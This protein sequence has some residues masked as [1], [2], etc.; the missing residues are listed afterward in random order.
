MNKLDSAVQQIVSGVPRCKTKTD[1]RELI[2]KVLTEYNDLKLEICQK[3]IMEASHHLVN[4]NIVDSKV[5]RHII[6]T[7]EDDLRKLK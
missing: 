4:N 7:A 5:M 2:A 3:A 6:Y 1:V